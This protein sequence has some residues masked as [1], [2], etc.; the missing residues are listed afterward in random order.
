MIVEDNDL[1]A[2][3]IEAF[4][5]YYGH[6]VIGPFASSEEVFEAVQ[7]EKP[8]YVLMDINL[9]GTPDGLDC[10]RVLFKRHNIPVV[11]LSSDSE[12]ARQGH[13]VALGHIAK[14]VSGHGLLA[15]LKAVEDMVHGKPPAHVP[16]G[17][18]VFNRWSDARLQ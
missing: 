10:A 7:R 15:S 2:K 17:M 11:F 16:A 18:T 1:V 9:H 5:Q 6:Q 14:P 13:G 12:R 8:D 3:S 4:L